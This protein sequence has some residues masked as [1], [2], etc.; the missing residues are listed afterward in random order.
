VLCDRAAAARLC[1]AASRASDHV[2]IVLGHREPGIS[3]EHRISAHSRARLARA[4]R[5]CQATPIRAVVLTGFTHTAGLSEAEQ[6][7]REWPLTDVPVLL[8]VAG[9]NTAENASRSLPIVLAL[10]VADRVSIVT[11]LCTCA[12]R[13]SSPRTEHS[14]MS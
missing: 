12:R 9:R 8:E 5:L 14:A 10:G 11:S 4:T 2:A 6:M 3:A 1:P 7:A 13:T